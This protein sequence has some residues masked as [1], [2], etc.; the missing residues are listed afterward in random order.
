MWI[1]YLDLVLIEIVSKCMLE[2]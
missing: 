2:A 1:K